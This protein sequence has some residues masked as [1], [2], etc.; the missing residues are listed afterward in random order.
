[1]LKHTIE[2]MANILVGQ[3]ATIL[4]FAAIILGSSIGIEYPDLGEGISTYVDY[5]VL[6]LVFC[7]L[8]EVEYKNILKSLN[9]LTFI[10]SAVV[11]NFVVIPVLGFAFSAFFL[12]ANQLLFVGLM[13]YFISPCTD[14]FLG[15]TRLAKGNTA[16]GAALLPINLVIQLLLYPFYVQLFGL[17]TLDTDITN[18]IQTLWQ[19]F[20]IPLYLRLLFDCFVNGY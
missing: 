1:M 13:I 2:N 15:F 5:T 6:C 16:L 9:R 3:S 12:Q 20:L 7:L 17:S 19:W 10:V 14:W 11:A 4:L 18:I 8:F